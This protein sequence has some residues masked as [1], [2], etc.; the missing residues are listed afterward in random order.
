MI[1]DDLREA[2]KEAVIRHFGGEN[3]P[4]FS[5]EIPEN[6]EHGDY[7]TN[8]AL[9]LGGKIKKNPREVAELLSRELESKNW[10]VSVAGPGF[11]NFTLSSKTLEKEFGEILKKKEKYGSGKKKKEKIQVEFISANPTGPL[12]LANGRGGF[13][14]D[15]LSNIFEKN[16]YSVEREY[17]VNDAGNQVLTL[18]KSL[19]AAEDIIPEGDS[20]YKGSYIK[21]WASAHKTIVKKNEQNPMELGKVA[22]KDFL[23]N[24]R[25]AIEKKSGIHF[26]RYT[27]EDR[28]IHKKGLVKKA[29]T[30]F[31]EKGFVYEK[32]GA[33]WLK[34]TEFGDDK[35]RVLI[36]RDSY[37]TYFL[38]DSGHYLETKIRKFDLKINIIG[39]DH[40]GYVKRIQA[41]AEIIGFRGSK[42]IVTQVIRLLRGE[43]EVKMSKRKG[44]FVTFE[45]LIDEVGQ[46]A[47][48]YFFLEKSPDTHIDF[49]LNLAKERS[50]K[51]PVYYVQYAYVRAKSILEKTKKIKHDRNS[52]NYIEYLCTPEEC[53]LIKKLIQLPE[54]IEDTTKDFHV[55]RVIRYAH[56]LARLF[57]TFYEK[58]RV[59]TDD[60]MLTRARIDLDRAVIQVLGLSLDLLGI[61]KP[62]KM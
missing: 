11:L 9:L 56:E 23:K 4:I 57:N 61:S 42:I 60:P 21:E 40:Y 7:A 30:L 38:A 19:L 53:V 14:G 29:L 26:D 58:N 13:L 3:L 48:R 41:A 35:D 22:A 8:I 17:Y 52:P 36:T 46:D 20:F 39:P 27:S 25:A 50:V 18:G 62:K 49:D 45:D 24:I 15:A 2:I 1:R 59:I 31:E 12:T 5:L 55:H 34:T 44:E 6:R 47:A 51:N 28:D 54:I 33:R 32:E 43:E 37:P 16:G 10:G